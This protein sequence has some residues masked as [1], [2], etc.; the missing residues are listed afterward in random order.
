MT[1]RPVFY[2]RKSHLLNADDDLAVHEQR[3]WKK[4]HERGESDPIILKEPEGHRSAY[5]DTHRPR[6][7]EL[8]K[9]LESD[10]ISTLYIND[11][12]RTWRN[13]LEWLLFLVKCKEHHTEIIPVTEEPI[14]NIDN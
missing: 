4:L 3:C 5:S 12:A 8:E 1:R 9:L 11:R 2:L 7:Q 6:Y 14:G 10:Q 13:D